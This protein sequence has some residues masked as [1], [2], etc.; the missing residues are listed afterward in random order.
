MQ[1][2]V[3]DLWGRLRQSHSFSSE[4]S[5]R[6]EETLQQQFRSVKSSTAEGLSRQ[7]D[8]LAANHKR[9]DVQLNETMTTL[10]QEREASRQRLAQ[11]VDQLKMSFKI[12]IAED[13]H[14]GHGEQG[15]FASPSAERHSSGYDTHVTSAAGSTSMDNAYSALT[16]PARGSTSTTYRIQPVNPVTTTSAH[17]GSDRAGGLV[18][19]SFRVRRATGAAAS[20]PISSGAPPSPAAYR[21]S[22]GH[23]SDLANLLKSPR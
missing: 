12:P 20:F 19:A 11:L 13:K 14:M 9:A 23:L 7:V 17:G 10:Q 3:V 18:G 6:F 2:E 15:L 22:A 8:F 21:S 4:L 1:S 5:R 16:Q